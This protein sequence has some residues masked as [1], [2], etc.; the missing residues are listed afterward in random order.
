M[1]HQNSQ[2]RYYIPGSVYFITINTFNKFSYFKQ[3]ILCELFIDDLKICKKLKQFE[4]LGFCLLFDHIH[5]LIQP[6]DGYNI[7]QIM[8]SLKGNSSR[9]INKIIGF[10]WVE[11]DPTLGRLRLF[12]NNFINKYGI[13]KSTLPIFKWQKSFHDHIIRNDKDLVNHYNYTVYNFKKHNL[14]D[15]WKYTSLNYQELIDEN[16]I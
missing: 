9:N 13:D 12:R 6:N 11:G 4:L 2:K 5:L 7:S 3:E 15:N 1:L 10:S 8:E 16:K 14:P